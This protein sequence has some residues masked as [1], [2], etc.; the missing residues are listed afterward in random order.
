[1]RAA[2]RGRCAAFGTA[3]LFRSTERVDDQ[4]V[5][6]VAGALDVAR[7]AS[8]EVLHLPRVVAR[9]ADG[10]EAVEAVVLRLAGV[11]HRGNAVEALGGGDVGVAG[12]RESGA[13]QRALAEFGVRVWARPVERGGN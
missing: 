3:M 6:R 2:G 11:E 8:A 7:E 1:M 4:L 10:G 13:A 5:A 12:F 9:E